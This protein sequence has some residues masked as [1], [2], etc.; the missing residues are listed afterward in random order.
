[1]QRVHLYLS[2]RLAFS[3]IAAALFVLVFKPDPDFLSID[4]GMRCLFTFACVCVVDAVERR[5]TRK[6]ITLKD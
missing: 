5:F 1:M 4:F 6:N 2:K 3:V